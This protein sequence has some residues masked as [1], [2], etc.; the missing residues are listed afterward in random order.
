MISFNNLANINKDKLALICCAFVFFIGNFDSSV[1]GAALSDISMLYHIEIINLKNLMI[2][3]LISYTLAIPL[4]EYL[5]TKYG[6]RSIFMISCVGF[7]VSSFMCGIS[8]GLNELVIARA[9]Q[10]FFAGCFTP[11]SRILIVKTSS[12]SNLAINLTNIQTLGL[13]GTALGPFIGGYITTYLG[14]RYIFFINIPICLVTL[15][16]IYI[17]IEDNTRNKSIK[18]DLKGYLY[19]VSILMSL[20]VTSVLIEHDTDFLFSTAVIAITII[21][22]SIITIFSKK[23]FNRK[24]H[25]I[26]NFSLF[27]T[28]SLFAFYCK[29]S[30]VA[31]QFVSSISFILIIIGGSIFNYNSLQVGKLLLAFGAGLWVSKLIT[32]PLL[33]I[34]PIEFLLKLNS[35]LFIFISLLGFAIILYFTN[36]YTLYIITF[37]FGALISN[38]IGLYNVLT[39]Q[40]VNK[41]DSVAAGSINSL[42]IYLS[43]STAIAIFA[44]LFH[45]FS[46]ILIPKDAI[47]FTIIVLNLFLTWATINLFFFKP[48]AKTNI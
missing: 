4:V 19:I 15:F 47:F 12:P 32:K 14:W 44:Y 28:N 40:S 7:L 21:V 34:F 48:K 31:R 46:K 1:L 20:M 24:K 37:V 11:I 43:Q 25:T 10:G 30:T 22:I 3:F 27:T 8:T 9:L 35:T 6:L 26:V 16:L 33:K 41:E 39:Y 17:A 23:Y 29:C 42:I 13:L 38:I 45:L 36:V 18:L 2:G 5:I